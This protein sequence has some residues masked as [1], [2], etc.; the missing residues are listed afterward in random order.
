MTQAYYDRIYG[1]SYRFVLTYSNYLI[2]F[3]SVT[4]PAC[5]EMVKDLKPAV[6]PDR[7]IKMMVVKDGVREVRV[8]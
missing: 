1:D 4:V 7:E 5:E 3:K 6:F 8:V 2:F